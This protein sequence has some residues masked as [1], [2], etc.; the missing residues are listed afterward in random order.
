MLPFL[1]TLTLGTLWAPPIN[2][3]EC[4]PG[5]GHTKLMKQGFK[6]FCFVTKLFEIQT[7]WGG[8]VSTIRNKQCTDFSKNVFTS[9]QFIF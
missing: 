3:T 2:I 5:T 1:N 8:D 4:Q 6:D 9:N 7:Y